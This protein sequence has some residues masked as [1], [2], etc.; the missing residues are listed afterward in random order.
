M[1]LPE[2]GG[3][4]G[5]GYFVHKRSV[6][7]SIGGGTFLLSMES[8]KLLGSHTVVRLFQDASVLLESRCMVL[9]MA[10]QLQAFG[11]DILINEVLY[12]PDGSDDG[13]EWVEICNAGSDTV[14]L[15]GWALQNAGTSWSDVFVLE[16]GFLAPGEYLVI[17]SGS[18]SHP[19]SFDPN[20]Q[21]GGS[22]SDGL[23]LVDA[24]GLVIDTVLYDS[25]NSNG[26]LDDLGSTKGGTAPEASSGHS[27]G[28]SPDCTDTDD[29]T[30]DFAEF[31]TPSPGAQNTAGG[32]SGVCEL[33][34]VKIN[35]FMANPSGSDSGAEWVELYNM[36]SVDLDLSGWLLEYGNNGY[37]TSREIP[38]GLILAAEGFLVLGG[39]N[40]SDA[41]GVISLSLG[42]ASSSA[43]GLRLVDCEGWVVDTVVYG[44][45]SDS[46][47]PWEDDQGVATSFAP[48][49][50]DGVSTARIEDGVDTDQSGVDFSIADISTPGRSNSEVPECEGSEFIKLNEFLANPDGDDSGFEWIEL[51]NT[52]SESIDLTGWSIQWGTSSWN[53]SLDLAE[54]VL[55]GAGEFYLIGEDSVS[56]ADLFGSLGLGN[57]SN[58]DGL[59][60]LHCGGGAADTVIYGGSNGDG[61]LDDTGAKATSIAPALES[62]LSL[63]RCVDGEDTDSN[64]VDWVVSE[65]STPGSANVECVPVECEAGTQTIKIN[66]VFPNPEG[67]DSD[68]EWIELYNAGDS[69]QGLDGWT[70]EQATSSWSVAY[71]F[72]GGV[73]IEP[74]EYVL[75]GGA[76]VPD[77]W[78]ASSLSL[79]NASTAPDGVRLLDCTDSTTLQDTVLWGDWGDEA[80]DPIFDD[81]GEQTFALMPDDGLSIGRFPDGQDSDDNAVDFGTN[82]NPTPGRANE[83]GSGGGGSG[84]GVDPDTKGCGNKDVAVDPATKKCGLSL[85]AQRMGYWALLLAS[86]AAFRRRQK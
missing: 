81:L 16:D 53:K 70:I 24:S 63:G 69:V 20:L 67:T 75:V 21:N 18:D 64:G 44:E 62:G 19:G 43:D 46:E 66:E 32:G 83:E 6:N 37:S 51:V 42:N 11:Q 28:R 33:G 77:A 34:D 29:S 36:G 14:D 10:F 49:P 57:G 79:G 1:K 68:Q 27:I 2:V 31:E 61:W 71:T 4:D 23:R 13:A 84:G 56:D 50:G 85:S 17:G 40:V 5:A 55:L 22:S 39:E 30:I 38:D 72:P 7:Q 26:L 78:L 76:E 74:G 47:D 80:E 60:L 73:D 86:L 9:L 3:C 12:N 59:R 41:D 54:G 48:G 8:A 52:G 82:M 35:E 25:P 58:G 65:A 15:S 45:P